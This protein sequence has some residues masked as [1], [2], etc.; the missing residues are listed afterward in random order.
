MDASMATLPGSAPSCCLCQQV[1]SQCASRTPISFPVKLRH[2]PAGQVDP[3]L[4]VPEQFCDQGGHQ[5]DGCQPHQ[6]LWASYTFENKG[7]DWQASSGI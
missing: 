5:D 1:N 6:L 4:S 3:G 7:V 2:L